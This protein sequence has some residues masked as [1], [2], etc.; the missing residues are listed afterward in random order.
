M[1]ALNASS[2]VVAR[3][4]LWLIARP[5]VVSVI[6]VFVTAL[7]ARRLGADR[8]GLLLLL[9]A[10]VALFAPFVSFGLRPYMVREVATKREKARQIV[11]EMLVL[12]LGLAAV[13]TVPVILGYPVFFGRAGY[14]LVLISIVVA[15]VFINAASS[16][17]LDTLHGLENMKVAAG[18]MMVAG[19]VVQ[20]GLAIAVL[21]DHDIYPFALAYLIGGGVLLI[22]SAVAVV[23]TIGAPRLTWPRLGHLRQGWRFFLPNLFETLRQRTAYFL[24]NHFLG[25]HAVGL[26]GAAQALTQKFEMLHDGIASAS[27][28]RVAGLHAQSSAVLNDLVRGTAKV[29]LLISLP[30]AS[31]LFFVSDE[32]IDFLYGESYQKAAAILPLLGATVPFVFFYSF[33][34]SLLGAIRKQRKVVHISALGTIVSMGFLLSGVYYGGLLGAA[35]ALFAGYVILTVLAAAVY[36]YEKGAPFR[37]QDM[38]RTGVANMVMIAALYLVADLHLVVQVFVGA[39]VYAA[40]V[41]GL[42]LILAA[43]IKAVL[44]RPVSVLK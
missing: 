41:F 12:R 5:M 32:I 6:S 7:V 35:I 40:A 16:C 23:R 29:L 33:F 21:L 22:V 27:F 13:V 14:D 24:I 2:I 36:W 20:A 10:Y 15:Q 26:F 19:L 4:S 34:A 28:P 17:F 30:L 44:G 42:R 39:V 1:S 11:E 9:V 3:N 25:A 37:A 43:E 31:G 38:L 8:Y 18:A